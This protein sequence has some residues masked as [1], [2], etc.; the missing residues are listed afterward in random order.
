MVLQLLIFKFNII[1]IKTNIKNANSKYTI[2]NYIRVRK[3]LCLLTLK[4]TSD[5]K[6]L[7]NI[8]QYSII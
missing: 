4:H 8:H 2:Y 6:N 5:F 3:L 1:F 7:L